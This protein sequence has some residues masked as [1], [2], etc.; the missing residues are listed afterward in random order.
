MANAHLSPEQIE[1]YQNDA[2]RPEE[3]VDT[4]T[5]LDACETCRA[6]ATANTSRPVALAGL[7]AEVIKHSWEETEHLTEEQ[8]AGYVDETLDRISLQIVEGHLGMCAQCVEDIRQLRAFRAMLSTYPARTMMPT[9]AA[10]PAE[11][12]GLIWR[13]NLE[14]L[15]HDSH[16][17][18]FAAA[19]GVCA[20]LMVVSYRSGL[21]RRDPSSVL[22][23]TQ[24]QI[25]FLAG[26]RSRDAEVKAVN[27]R[28]QKASEQVRIAKSRQEQDERN[29][30]ALQKEIA[31][32]T[33]AKRGPNN[34]T[35]QLKEWALTGG[36]HLVEGEHGQ[37]FLRIP[38]TAS[39]AQMLHAAL[40]EKA[41][42]HCAKST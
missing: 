34:P 9:V 39:D 21:G 25:A 20:L 40:E 38:L 33:Q 18:T 29:R 17:L 15:R 36:S 10:T 37:A 6:L 14:W 35:P 31:R 30:L 22:T 8:Q 1:R 5:H 26:A 7:Q 19:T 13:R 23:P 28:E 3:I 2:L 24:K 4:Y 42:S 32:L 12:L 11:R 27:E 41:A 16:A